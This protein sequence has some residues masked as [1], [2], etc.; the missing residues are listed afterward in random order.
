MTI[1]TDLS[2]PGVLRAGINLGNILL[3]TG[4]AADG[5]PEGVAPSLAGR[6]ADHLGLTVELVPFASPGE[7]ADALADDAWD[8]ALIAEEPERAK[9]IAFVDAYVEIEAT[10]MVPEAS[11]LK[12][13]ADVDA[14]GVRIAV[15]D[16]SAYD[17]Y[18]SRTL[19]KAELVRAKGLQGALD[20]YVTEKL[21]A[22]AG[23]RPALKENAADL[24]GQRILD[25]RYTAVRQAVG[26]KPKNA[27]L[28]A[29]IAAYL[30]TA[31]AD[32]T[33]AGLLETFG[34]QEKLS[35]AGD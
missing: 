35:V 29:A 17:L 25:G 6:I 31:K 8:I 34:V 11:P 32:G 13:I 22:L 24:G 28:Q 16:R 3:V 19:Q 12:T 9:T 2:R 1:D 4:K 30:K 15:S 10:Y 7:V 14:A 21:D 33:I 18:L 5:D 20:L 26:T 27:A 23:L